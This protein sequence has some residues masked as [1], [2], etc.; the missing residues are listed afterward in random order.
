MFLYEIEQGHSSKPTQPAKHYWLKRTGQ[1]N[2]IFSERLLYG[3]ALVVVTL[4]GFM[5]L[6]SRFF[7]VQ[8][9]T[10]VDRKHPS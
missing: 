5:L 10:S 7:P 2:G 3:V 4:V 6:F 8:P 1:T 9:P